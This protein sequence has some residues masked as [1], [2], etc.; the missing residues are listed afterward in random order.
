MKFQKKKY[1]LIAYLFLFSKF[2]EAEVPNVDLKNLSAGKSEFTKVEF[3][4][5]VKEGVVLIKQMAFGKPAYTISYFAGGRPIKTRV[6][7]K[8]YY[9]NLLE[10]ASRLDPIF[11]D[12]K[13]ATSVP[14]RQ[15]I[16]RISR[17][18]NAK[19]SERRGCLE[20]QSK[21]Q[22]ELFVKWISSMKNFTSGKGI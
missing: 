14:C 18:E 22:S 9:Q 13:P 21:S 3:G 12:R 1:F 8:S 11:K 2:A 10:Q 7:I 5:D 19:I 15:A 20:N 17:D 4:R 16:R 6:L